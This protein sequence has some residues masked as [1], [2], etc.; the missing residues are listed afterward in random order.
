MVSPSAGHLHGDP[1]PFG[2]ARRFVMHRADV[3][4]NELQRAPVRLADPTRRQQIVPHLPDIEP[5]GGE[6][7]RVRLARE[8]EI[9]ADGRRAPQPPPRLPATLSFAFSWRHWGIIQTP[10]QVGCQGSGK[11]DAATLR[12]RCD[13]SC[14][15]TSYPGFE[16]ALRGLREG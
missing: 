9:P 5:V 12:A 10:D 1:G 16:A 4:E 7:R 14:V 6:K 3:L 15:A 11:A 2:Q 13:A 8:D